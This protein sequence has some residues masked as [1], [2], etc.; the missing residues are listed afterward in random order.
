MQYVVISGLMHPRT[1]YALEPDPDD[2]CIQE[3]LSHSQI[4]RLPSPKQA[5]VAAQASEVV[6]TS[7][8]SISK[9]LRRF[10][11]ARPRPSS[12]DRS[13]ECGSSYSLQ[14]EL[15]ESCG[16][17]CCHLQHLEEILRAQ[18]L[19]IKGH[20][21]RHS[22]EKHFQTSNSFDVDEEE[23]LCS[24]SSNQVSWQQKSHSNSQATG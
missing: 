22:S 13:D 7:A 9:K 1:Q 15:A 5:S 10:R 14:Q 16:Q 2:D 3:I 17:P 21:G 12:A 4:R 23:K 24:S 19:Q 6:G 18:G 20:C 8:S 11:K